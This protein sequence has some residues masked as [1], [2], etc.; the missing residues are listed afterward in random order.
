MPSQEEPVALSSLYSV[1]VKWLY[2]QPMF[3]PTVVFY[4]VSSGSLSKIWTLFR[5]LHTVRCTKRVVLMFEKP[6]TVLPYKEGDV[7]LNESRG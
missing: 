4:L 7:R 3:C 5:V 2:I 6:S 1:V